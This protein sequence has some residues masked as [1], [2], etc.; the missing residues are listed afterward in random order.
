MLV[1]GPGILDQRG[2]LLVAALAKGHEGAGI[3]P[4]RSAV[5]MSGQ[6]LLERAVIVLPKQAPGEDV[7]NSL[8]VIRVQ[9]QHVAVVGEG[10]LNVAKLNE[11]AREAGPGPHIRAC[12]EKAPEVAGIL[13]EISWPERQFACLDT[14]GIQV[15]GL[16][17][18][19]GFFG[20]EDISVSAER[21]DVECFAGERYSGTGV[22]LLPCPVHN[23]L[24]FCCRII[25]AA[26]GD[27]ARKLSIVRL[28]GNAASALAFGEVLTARFERGFF[29]I[30]IP[31]PPTCPDFRT[32][33]KL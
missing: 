24:R 1:R 9:L 31:L 20:E 8:I 29:E 16:L 33:I 27:R 4:E 26:P 13:F 15:P 14:L 32:A 28:S 19:L 2:G 5:L 7:S 18:R 10:T 30:G 3:E 6:Q 23:I 22:V 17:D 25:T 21:R 12:F 11:R